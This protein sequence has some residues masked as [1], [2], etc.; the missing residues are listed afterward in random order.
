M[1]QRILVLAILI[2]GFGAVAADTSTNSP[3]PQAVAREVIAA[4]QTGQASQ[5]KSNLTTDVVILEKGA[6]DFP[7]DPLIHSA[8][9]MCYLGQEK[10]EAAITNLKIAYTNSDKDVSI[11]FMYA[12]ALKMNQ[13]PLK[14]YELDKEMVALHPDVPQLQISL[15]T[16][17]MT[18]QKYDEAIAILEPLLQ[19]APAN[20]AAQDKSVLLFMLGTCYLYKGN[21]TKAIET[22]ENAQSIMPNMA[23]DLT[24]LGEAYLKNGDLE[25]AGET[26][27]QALAINPRIPPAL[28]YKGVY[29]EK[30][31]DPG[32]AQKN[33]QEAY[34]YGKQRLQDNGED[35]YLMFLVCQR[36]SKTDEG[37]N[38]KTEAKKLLFSY[39]APWKQKQLEAAD[40][41]DKQEKR[42]IP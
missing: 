42:R 30:T 11:G 12:L 26:L 20:L 34:T 36:L 7:K 27:D 41:K 14:A 10:K 17:D 18:I 22:L 33:F 32:R 16:L 15:A 6:G 1:K 29:Y 5:L 3:T 25:K 19:K 40:S 9:A 35:Y 37:K 4:F 2:S 39:E 8:L 24:V 38:Y 31:G 28:Y 23:M 13:Q 21:H